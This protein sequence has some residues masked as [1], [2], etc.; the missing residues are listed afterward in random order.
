MLTGEQSR[1]QEPV[2]SASAAP[3]PAPVLAET[4]LFW[5][6]NAVLEGSSFARPHERT[7]RSRPHRTAAIRQWLELS[8]LTP[9]RRLLLAAAGF[10]ADAARD[11][12]ATDAELE[13]LSALN[14]STI[15]VS[16]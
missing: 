10:S 3:E 7:A 5:K 4:A 1:S 8:E 13:V 14:G 16:L 15:S 11:V 2:R 12:T 9:E 6:L